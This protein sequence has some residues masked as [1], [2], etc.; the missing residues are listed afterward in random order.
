MRSPLNP[1]GAHLETADLHYC[2]I[3]AFLRKTGSFPR[4]A[5]GVESS[6]RCACLSVQ[7]LRALTTLT[8]IIGRIRPR[9]HRLSSTHAAPFLL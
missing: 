7:V 2:N 6:R 8:P 9:G 3:G 4:R 1:D 5:H